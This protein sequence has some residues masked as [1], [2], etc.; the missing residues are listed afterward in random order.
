[1]FYWPK[2]QPCEEK[3]KPSADSKAFAKLLLDNDFSDGEQ[4][5]FLDAVLARRTAFAR[6]A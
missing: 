3:P 6:S 5:Q 1:V 2:S 4:I